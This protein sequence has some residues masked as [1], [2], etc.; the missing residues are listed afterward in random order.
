M[1][2]WAVSNIEN[3][4]YLGPIEFQD[5]T[6]EWHNF[7]VIETDDKFIFGSACN[8]RFL[9]SGYIEKD[10]GDFFDLYHDLECY[11]NGEQTSMIV[12][13]ERM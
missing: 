11:Y 10:S 4:K 8:I 12:Y 9:E 7:E 3:G 13:N 5:N 1:K 2:T 6:G